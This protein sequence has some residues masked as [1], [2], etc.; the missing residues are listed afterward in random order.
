MGLLISIADLSANIPMSLPI[1][2]R[3]FQKL[4]E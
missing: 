1:N 4:I 2:L 3:I